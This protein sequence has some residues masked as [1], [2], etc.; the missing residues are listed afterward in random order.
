MRYTTVRCDT[1]RRRFTRVSR[2]LDDARATR[3][4]VRR[5]RE[6]EGSRGFIA[7]RAFSS[8]HGVGITRLV[9]DLTSCRFA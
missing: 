8:A 5:R 2:R 3:P 7:S 1:P 6:R 9:G 4:T